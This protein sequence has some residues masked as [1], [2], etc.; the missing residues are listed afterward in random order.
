M[1][2]EAVW[3]KDGKEISWVDPVE[4]LRYDQYTDNIFNIEVHNGYYWYSA[5]DFNEI[6]DDFIIR[7]KK[8]N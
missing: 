2:L 4:K 5:E 8:E 6:P 3:F 1:I 7:I